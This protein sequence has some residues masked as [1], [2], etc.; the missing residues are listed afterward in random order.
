MEY[1]KCDPKLHLNIW[2]TCGIGIVI[3]QMS[4]C[5]SSMGQLALG[6]NDMPKLADQISLYTQIIY[7]LESKVTPNPSGAPKN[8]AANRER[9]F[10]FY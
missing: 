8:L 1:S 6:Q 4:E 5:D 10:N 9:S 2:V 3:V 7:N